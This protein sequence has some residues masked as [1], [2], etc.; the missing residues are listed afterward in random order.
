MKK[1]VLIILFFLFFLIYLISIACN[2]EVVSYVAKPMLTI[3]LA[4]Y[5]LN[6]T[7]QVARIFRI[8]MSAA[9][10]FSCTGDV[11]LL[12]EDKGEAF[13]LAGIG[14]FLFTHLAYIGFFLKIRYSNYPL[15]GCQWPF[16]F[17]TA[18]ALLLFIFT[19]LP[20]LGNMSIPVVIYAIF[21]SLTLLT[22][23][24]AFRLKEQTMGWFAV[25]GAIL[26]I[27][28]DTLIA[29]DHFYH[30]VPAGDFLVALTYGLAQWGLCTGGL[31]YLQIR[32]EYGT[33]SMRTN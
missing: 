9:L 16:I 2:R 24:H 30:A 29:I 6:N 10:F 19:M 12:F 31:K 15:P 21:I 17:L 7:K 32:Q 14:S 8:L 20:Y 5:F 1:R 28:S 18:A 13:F 26:F 4:I 33:R 27:A 23:M 11:F 25:T 3:L 22:S